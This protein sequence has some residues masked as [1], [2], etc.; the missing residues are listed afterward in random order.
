MA[1]AI[2]LLELTAE[3]LEGNW[4]QGVMTKDAEPDIDRKRQCLLG[5]LCTV[6]DETRTFGVR[7]F[8]AVQALRAVTGIG[9]GRLTDWNDVTGRTEAE[10]L[11]ALRTAAVRLRKQQES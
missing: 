9:Q 7:F 5:W 4:C 11:Y 6:S 1:S 10:V 8:R 2:E 3:A